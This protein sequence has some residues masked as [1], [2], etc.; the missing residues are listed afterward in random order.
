MY[1]PS[2]VRNIVFFARRREERAFSPSLYCWTIFSFD[3]DEMQ[4]INLCSVDIVILVINKKN[5]ERTKPTVASPAD[6]SRPIDAEG[7]SSFPPLLQVCLIRGPV[8]HLLNRRRAL[9]VMLPEDFVSFHYLR[10]TIKLAAQVSL[11]HFSLLNNRLLSRR[12]RT[13]EKRI[14]HDKAAS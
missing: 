2:K 14:R 9:R 11:L 6:H 3:A 5:S 10:E 13:Q 12:E 1:R 4:I 8:K 7:V